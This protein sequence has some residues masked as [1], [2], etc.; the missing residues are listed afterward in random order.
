MALLVDV[1]EHMG[2]SK[3]ISAVALC[4]HTHLGPLWVCSPTVHLQLPTVDP[5]MRVC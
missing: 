3:G 2:Y 1:W 5:P 4:E